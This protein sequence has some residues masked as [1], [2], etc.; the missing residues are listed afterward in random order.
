MK[1]H[2]VCP[3]VHPPENA[4]HRGTKDEGGKIALL[5]V[6]VPLAYPLAAPK[7]PKGLAHANTRMTCKAC[8]AR[9]RTDGS[10]CVRLGQTQELESA[11]EPDWGPKS[12]L[13]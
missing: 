12:E 5:K 8:A 3:K 2:N 4:F 13:E 7:F 11:L 9:G 10:N 6:P 1:V